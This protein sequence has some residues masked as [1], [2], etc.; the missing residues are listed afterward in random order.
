[1]QTRMAFIQL[2]HFQRRKFILNSIRHEEQTIADTEF[3]IVKNKEESIKL[4][5]QLNQEIKLVGQQAALVGVKVKK[6]Q[7]AVIRRNQ[8]CIFMSR[9]RLIF[10]TWRKQVRS[11]TNFIR[12]ITRVISQSMRYNG[13]LNIKERSRHVHRDR[14]IRLRMTQITS[15]FFKHF[16]LEVFSRWK[17]EMLAATLETTKTISRLKELKTQ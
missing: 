13:F 17:M 9:K 10:E 1:M 16:M 8:D 15:R 5:K 14:K 2:I 6:V 4:N 7:T 12:C 3:A 11:E